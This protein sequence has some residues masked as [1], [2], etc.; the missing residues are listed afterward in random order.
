MRSLS[1]LTLPAFWSAA[2]TLTSTRFSQYQ[3]STQPRIVETPA[4]TE[5]RIL[6]L[7]RPV[8]MLNFPC[9]RE[10][11]AVETPNEETRQ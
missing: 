3:L 7:T 2:V 5:K 9:G 11:P 8:P 10:K 1:T 4:K 6:D